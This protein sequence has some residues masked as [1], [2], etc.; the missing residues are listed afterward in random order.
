MMRGA[1]SPERILYRQSH[2]VSGHPNMLSPEGDD[3][4]TQSPLHDEDV[5]QIMSSPRETDQLLVL[6]PD[7][8]LHRITF[9][10]THIYQAQDL[11]SPIHQPKYH[12]QPPQ[13]AQ[14]HYDWMIF[15]A[16]QL[17][18]HFSHPSHQILMNVERKS[19]FP[20]VV[21]SSGNADLSTCDLS[22]ELRY[23][24]GMYSLVSA[25][26]RPGS[27]YENVESTR[28]SG[29]IIC[30]FATFPGEDSEKLESNWISW[31]GK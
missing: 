31:T 2:H 9:I 19:K 24:D 8:C 11:L 16:K 14:Q 3:I 13:P 6:T 28:P 21:Y 15:N 20:F 27:G 10:E 7:N 18:S 17:R 4:D 29:F 30:A 1:S 26:T 23:T 25:I 5:I 12:R 22:P